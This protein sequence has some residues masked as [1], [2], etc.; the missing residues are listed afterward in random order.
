[1]FYDIIIWYLFFLL[2]GLIALPLVKDIGYAYSKVVALLITTYLTFII[3]YLYRYDL[4]TVVTS[5]VLLATIAAGY[6]I[7]KKDFKIQWK[8]FIEC[9][10][11]FAV[12]FFIFALVRAFSPEIYF[13]GGEKLGEFGFLNAILRSGSFPPYDPYF[14][15]EP[16]QYYYF[17]HLIIANIIKLTG[18]SPEVG[19]NLATASLFALSVQIAYGLGLKLN[20]HRMYAVITVVFILILGNLSGIIQFLIQHA[21]D[22]YSAI[23]FNYWHA[24]RII[25]DTINEFPYFSFLHGDLHPHMI[26][27]PFKILL[28]TLFLQLLSGK[29]DNTGLVI[30]V[31]FFTGFLAP[32]NTW[33]YPVFLL[34]LIVILCIGRYSS[35]KIALS[36]IA[37]IIPYLPFLLSTTG[38]GIGFVTERTELINFFVIHGLF[39]F[40]LFSYLLMRL[41]RKH[42]NYLIVL[43]LLLLPI[44]FFAEFQILFLL[45]PFVIAPLWLRFWD[46]GADNAF[47]DLLILL[48]ALI[49]LGC[50]LFYIDDAFTG[51]IERLNTVFKFYLN[52]W[53]FWAVASVYALKSVIWQLRERGVM[54]HIWTITFAILLISASIYPVF[55]T[56]GRSHAFEVKP[57]LDGLVWARE[58]FPSDM[59]ALDWINKN[60]SGRPVFLTVPAQDYRWDSRVASVTGFPIIIGWM[61]EEI[62]WREDREE[63]NRRLKSVSKVLSSDEI[64]SEVIEILENYNV[65]YIYIGEIERAKY[66][67][68]VLKFDGWAGC[69]V[70]FENEGVTIY[71]LVDENA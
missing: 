15:G 50:E 42:Q 40:I 48:G 21:S 71:E 11:I 16:I 51:K 67:D 38:R 66:P 62:M 6:M 61:G 55:A 9:E 64:D 18:I 59:D 3:G 56:S 14:G 30:V 7:Y 28:L 17:G 26:A 32:L 52:V 29:K 43:I 13:T 4:I 10:L 33:D 1:M 69:E 65:S 46:G 20:R 5:F 37:A 12:A 60:M 47:I 53:I 34:L 31:G 8:V 63:V 49:A 36:I 54:G 41:E 45:L 35:D 24:S 2:A 19:F 22:P 57:T 68:G 58:E 27:I 70:V 25:P 23:Y 39:L 44:S